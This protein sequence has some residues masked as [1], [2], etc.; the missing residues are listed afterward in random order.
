MTMHARELLNHLQDVMPSGATAS[1]RWLND[2]GYSR[3]T[4]SGYVHRG[5]LRR[6]AQGVYLRPEGGEEKAGQPPTHLL[7]WTALVLSLQNL[8]HE[9]VWPGGITALSLTGQSHYLSLGARPRIL[10]YGP[11]LPSWV[12]RVETD[13]ALVLRRANLFKDPSIGLQTVDPVARR[14]HAPRRTWQLTVSGPERAFFELLDEL[15]HEESFH[16]ADMI[17]EG[18]TMLRPRLITDL[19][20]C[21]RSVKVKRLYRVYVDRHPHPWVRHVDVDRIDFGSGKRSL[22]P[23]GRF[24]ARHGMTLPPEFVG[25]HAEEGQD[26]SQGL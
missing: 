21:C 18:L 3:A 14:I 22:V 20:A 12:T 24:D 1:A 15:P 9:K 4:L 17:F 6:L 26:D 13:A 23:G 2:K 5:H 25:H 7:P 11:N 10:L 8:L 19:L 16:N